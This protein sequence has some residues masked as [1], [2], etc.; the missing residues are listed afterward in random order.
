MSKLGNCALLAAAGLLLTGC[1]MAKRGER[2]TDVVDDEYVMRYRGIDDR[3][4]RSRFRWSR[5]P[6]KVDSGRAAFLLRLEPKETAALVISVSYEVDDAPPA[7]A[8]PVAKVWPPPPV[9][10]CAAP[11]AVWD[12]SPFLSLLLQAICSPRP[13]SKASNGAMRDMR[14]TRGDT[15]GEMA[16][17]SRPAVTVGTEVRSRTG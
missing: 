17:S 4:R 16:T 13:T 1:Y 2:L 15:A 8:A 3:E 14:I 12:V 5:P 11:V 6:D 7:D 9:A 10:V